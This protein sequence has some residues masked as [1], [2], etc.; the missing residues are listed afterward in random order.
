MTE[1][2]QAKVVDEVDIDVHPTPRPT[3]SAPILVEGV[4]VVDYTT[5][6][7]E[8]PRPHTSRPPL[9]VEDG[10]V[11]GVVKYVGNSTKS[12]ACLG[13]LCFGFPGLLFLACPMDE[14]D[15]YKVNGK[16]CDCKHHFIDYLLWILI[17]LF[18]MVFFSSM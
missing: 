18:D 10:G 3:P 7:D 8:N 2:I 5:T 16:V 15:G 12:A 13:C 17:I 11:W 1:I 14:K 9:G 4:T 6:Y